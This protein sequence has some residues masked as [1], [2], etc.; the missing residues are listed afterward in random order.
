MAA[1]SNMLE[2]GTP[3]PEFALPDTTSGVSVAATTLVGNVTVV[4]ILCNHCPYVKH[5]QR[6]L[7]AFGR[8]CAA[9][10]VKLVG[11]SSNDV[12]SYPEDGPEKMA[13]EARRA[14]Y[15]FPYLYDADQSAAKLFRAACTPEFY[16]FDTAGKLAYRGRFDETTPKTGGKATGADA[17]A[18]VEALLAGKSPAA[19][20]KPS[21]GCSIKWKEGNAPG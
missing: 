18:A 4:A 7:A 5:I 10:G 14:G 20:Q 16:V 6:E 15:S 3:L 19:D 17:R 12:A 21:I 1:A 8:D 2:L 13:E 11:I 9:K